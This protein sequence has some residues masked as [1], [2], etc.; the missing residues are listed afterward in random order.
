MTLATL[1]TRPF[2]HFIW[3]LLFLSLF[4]HPKFSEVKRLV[5]LFSSGVKIQCESYACAYYFSSWYFLICILIPC[6]VV[7]LNIFIILTFVYKLLTLQLNLLRFVFTNFYTNSSC[8][9]PSFECGINCCVTC[10]FQFLD[11]F[12]NWVVC[13]VCFPGHTTASP[14]RWY[15]N[16]KECL[17]Q[18]H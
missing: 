9:D 11:E 14:T 16:R 18:W 13:A 10:F 8:K 3:E 7:M 17:Y 4:G 5:M 12:C 15:I 1:I 2:A 6:T